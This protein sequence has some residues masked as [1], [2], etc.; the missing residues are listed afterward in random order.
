MPPSK[1]TLTMDY[2]GPHFLLLN[3]QKRQSINL[4]ILSKKLLSSRWQINLTLRTVG[5]AFCYLVSDTCLV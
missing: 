3:S 4:V 2:I 5:F 1:Y